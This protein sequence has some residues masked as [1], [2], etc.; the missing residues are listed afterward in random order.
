MTTVTKNTIATIAA[1]LEWLEAYNEQLDRCDRLDEDA[2]SAFAEVV[3]AGEGFDEQR[4]QR[5]VQRW[6]DDNLATNIPP[7]GMTMNEVRDCAGFTPYVLD[8]AAAL[9]AA[10]KAFFEEHTTEDDEE[11]ALEAHWQQVEVLAGFERKAFEQA[12]AAGN[13]VR[14]LVARKA[15]AADIEEARRTYGRTQLAHEAQVIALRIA[16]R[17]YE[18]AVADYT[19]T[20]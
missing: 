13:A 11:R 3:A 15:P 5:L 2:E 4:V 20:A 19:A 10:L 18:A 9:R 1:A 17:E 6:A 8:Q 7:A 12:K 16:R 14:A